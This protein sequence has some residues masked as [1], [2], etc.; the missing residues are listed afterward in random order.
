[1]EACSSNHCCREK[2]ISTTHSVC[3]SVAL[4]IQHV[5]PMRRIVFCDFPGSA[6]FVLIFSTTF[7]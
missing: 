3:V 7:I 4:D 5:R 1:M 2:V 6:L